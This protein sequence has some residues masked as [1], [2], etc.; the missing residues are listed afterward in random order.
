[1]G[2]SFFLRAAFFFIVVEVV[3]D[4]AVI[5]L[6]QSPLRLEAVLHL[7]NGCR[8]RTSFEIGADYANVII[9]M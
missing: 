4:P 5:R 8:F 2:S 1:L 3:D 9:N 7:P 6:M